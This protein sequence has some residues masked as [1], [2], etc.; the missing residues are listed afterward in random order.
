MSIVFA[1]ETA[2]IRFSD[3]TSFES[4]FN[5]SVAAFEFIGA[6]RE[7]LPDLKISYDNRDI[8][9]KKERPNLVIWSEGEQP[10]I[11]FLGRLIVN[12]SDAQI[13]QLDSG[14][15]IKI[16][17]QKKFDVLQTDDD[18]G[19]YITTSMQFSENLRFG[20][21]LVDGVGKAKTYYQ[22][23]IKNLTQDQLARFLY[24]EN[25]AKTSGSLERVSRFRSG[26]YPTLSFCIDSGRVLYVN[27]FVIE[28]RLS[29][30]SVDDASH[31]KIPLIIK[32]NSMNLKI[33]QW[34]D[35]DEIHFILP[36]GFYDTE[37]CQSGGLVTA[38]LFS[39]PVS[40][41]YDF[42]EL[43]VVIYE[44]FIED[45]S[46]RNLLLNALHDFD[47]ENTAIDRI[48]KISKLP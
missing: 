41:D 1:L 9:D 45:C 43:M 30:W 6:I 36:E 47:W 32:R 3:S 7:V 39:E 2:W 44:P 10:R 15:L 38:S 33:D 31:H 4:N 19:N 37:E 21:F 29:D 28:T 17:M 25:F 48:G 46:I 18:T 12:S 22:S 27:L 11:Q 14:H 24:A 42:S 20:M 34:F 40:K 8:P 16:T 5:T 35:P 26:R 13:P 23:L